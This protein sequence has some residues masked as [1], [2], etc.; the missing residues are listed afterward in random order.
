M[1]KK[2]LDR[3]LT[4]RLR[5][6][7]AYGTDREISKAAGTG[8]HPVAKTVEARIAEAVA[9]AV[10]PVTKRAEAAEARLTAALALAKGEADYLS[11]PDNDLTPAERL[12]FLDAD[13][14]ARAKTMTDRPLEK[15]T[16]RRVA[17]LPE[18]V[19]KQLEAGREAAER[20]A[21][22]TETADVEAFAKRATQ[23][24]QPAAFGE[25]LRRLAKGLG[26]EEERQK[27]YD[28]VVGVLDAYARQAQAAGLFK[29]LGGRGGGSGST[30]YDELIAKADELRAAVAKSGS[31]KPLTREQAFDRV[32]TDPANRE[33]VA[34]YKAEERRVA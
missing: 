15:M 11:H 20:V 1:P 6:K 17:D 5:R 30:A 31:D 22:M 32:Y 14:T 10:A 23:L 3:L 7:A 18:P 33:L 16:E 9:E 34:R 8:D 28:A 13:A 25:N 2:T 26:T 4:E 12:A 24:G 19:R 27:A 29:E 21:K